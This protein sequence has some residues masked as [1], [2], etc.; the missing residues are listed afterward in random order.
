MESHFGSIVASY[1]IFLRWLVGL[2]LIILLISSVFIILPEIFTRTIGKQK[3]IEIPEHIDEDK[4]YELRLIHDFDGFIKYSPFYFGYY[5]SFGT[6]PTYKYNLPLAYF[7]S[8][9]SILIYR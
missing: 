3:I 5:K 1:F 6:T 2:N 9:L 4:M 7:L 8:T